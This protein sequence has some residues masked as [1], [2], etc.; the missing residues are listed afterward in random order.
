MILRLA[1]TLLLLASCRAFV[2][3]PRNNAAQLLRSMSSA[4]EAKRKQHEKVDNDNEKPLV[5]TLGGG[6]SLMF[7]MA[8]KMLVWDVDNKDTNNSKQ[9]QGGVLPRW[10]P[11]AGISDVNPAFRTQ[12]PIM[13]NQGYAG[14]IWRNVR[15]RDKPSLWRYAL[16]TYNRMKQLEHDSST[17][18]LKIER[19]NVHHEGALLACDK[20]G[21]WQEALEIYHHVE[22]TATTNQ[23]VVATTRRR[24][25]V[26]VTDN[27][28]L[29]LVSACVRGSKQMDKVSTSIEERRAPL[30]AAT[31]V[32]L[33]M[34]EKHGLPLVARHLNP[35]AAAYQSLG[36]HEYATNLLQDNLTDRTSGPE[37]ENGDDP[38]NVH[39]IHAKDKASYAL[40]VNG[41]VSK[42]DWGDAV[43]ALKDMTEAG[44]YPNAR[45]VNRW[46]EISERKTRQRSTRSWKKKREEYWLESVR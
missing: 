1:V 40:M 7:E 42:G 29:S 43:D 33:D 19:T 3:S 12:S 14:I 21:L 8:R 6:T 16:R 32:L 31:Q 20:L 24:K 15:K 44:L 13:N 5:K 22:Q 11:H 34:P 41:A 30:D 25:A 36:L 45:H 18:P 38:L 17:S 9:Q 26:C 46:A 10:H 23:T 28:L 39:D 37:E 2:E 4:L 27:M 35:L